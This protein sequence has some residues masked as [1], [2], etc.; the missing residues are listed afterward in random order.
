MIFK[1][2]GKLYLYQSFVAEKYIHM[3]EYKLGT[4]LG[5]EGLFENPA[6]A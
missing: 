5:I 4:A 6:R 3:G 1:S 2:A